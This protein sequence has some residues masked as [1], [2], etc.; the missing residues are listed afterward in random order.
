[1]LKNLLTLNICAMKKVNDNQINI[2]GANS[3][4]RGEKAH[5]EANTSQH[6][7]N[8]ADSLP[9][10]NGGINR[11]ADEQ[12]DLMKRSDFRYFYSGRKLL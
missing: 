2:N 6:A 7:D 4:G 5:D 1:M 11:N 3:L 12:D 9:P 10:T 8:G